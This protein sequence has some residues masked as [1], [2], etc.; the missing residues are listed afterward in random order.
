MGGG[1]FG[2]VDFGVVDFG[3]E[4]EKRAPHPFSHQRHLSFF[5]KWGGCQE[6][7]KILSKK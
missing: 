1:G 2:V 6:K 4:N 7:N 5:E 3:G